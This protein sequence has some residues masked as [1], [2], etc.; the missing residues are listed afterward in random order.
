MQLFLNKEEIKD[1]SKQFDYNKIYDTIIIG[2]GPAGISAGIY[3]VRKGMET[4]IITEEI[5]GEVTLTWD[6]E[7]YPGFSK[8]TGYELAKKFEEHLRSFTV[9]IEN[10]KVVSIKKDGNTFIIK[11]DNNKIARSKTVIIATGKRHRHLNVKGEEEFIGKGVVFCATCDAPLFKGKNVVVVGGGNSGV[12][13]AIEVGK[14]AKKVYLVEVMDKLFA[15]KILIERLKELKN[16]EIL[17]KHKVNEIKGSNFV[18]S[19]ILEDISQKKEKEIKVDG[20]FVEIG[21]IPNSDIDIEPKIEKNR[22]DEIIVD[23]YCNTNINGL[24]AAG[25]V[26][27]IPEKQVIIAAGEGAKAAITAYKYLQTVS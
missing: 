2:G 25:D 19:I 10:A 20:I 14:I 18:E 22:Y 6:I 5:G 23:V 1:N 9:S 11:T 13:A 21:L 7:N 15:D 3:A 27:N 24:F 17:L 4:G 12:E 26:T 16:V 8:I